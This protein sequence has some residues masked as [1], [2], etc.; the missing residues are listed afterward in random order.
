MAVASQLKIKTKLEVVFFPVAT[1]G[2]LFVLQ[3]KSEKTT[4]SLNYDLSKYLPDESH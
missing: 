1:R 2:Q 3:K 4:C